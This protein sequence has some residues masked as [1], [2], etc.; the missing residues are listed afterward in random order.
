MKN[1]DERLNALPKFD[2]FTVSKA[3]YAKN[4]VAIRFISDGT[5]FKTWQNRLF[6]ETCGY[7]GY[8]RREGAY[9]VSIAKVEKFIKRLQDEIDAMAS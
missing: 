8:S 1:M 6:N 5:G 7:D 3:R 2:S 9:I 4:K